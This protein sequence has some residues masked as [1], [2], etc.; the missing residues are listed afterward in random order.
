LDEAVVVVRQTLPLAGV[1]GRLC[2]HPCEQG[3]R[4]GN[5]DDRQR[6]ATWNAS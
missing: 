6:S 2:H 4:R 5:W 3:C 1:L